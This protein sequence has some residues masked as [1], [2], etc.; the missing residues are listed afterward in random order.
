MVISRS[1]MSG[2]SANESTTPGHIP[3]R[4]QSSP[5]HIGGATDSLGALSPPL[6][7]LTHP[8]G[9]GPT[10]PGSN[11]HPPS[12]EATG[13]KRDPR[14]RACCIVGNAVDLQFSTGAG[15][16]PVGPGPGCNPFPA[17]A[18]VGALRPFIFWPFAFH[19]QPELGG[20]QFSS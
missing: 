2:R 10:L 9:Q 14:F 7:F 17:P 1:L 4:K 8:V 5:C 13:R 12:C 19:D 3:S 15:A 20:D 11:G 18:S 6:S 16:G